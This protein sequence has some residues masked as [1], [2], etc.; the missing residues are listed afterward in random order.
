MNLNKNKTRNTIEY[1]E[2]LEVPEQY[3]YKATKFFNDIK[4]DALSQLKPN[5]MLT[6]IGFNPKGQDKIF[7]L[8]LEADND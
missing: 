3:S 5:D 4:K 8:A 7:D 6:I 2:R 1:I